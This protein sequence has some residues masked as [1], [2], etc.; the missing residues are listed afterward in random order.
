MS[1]I[2]HLINKFC[3]TDMT[4][5]VY[6]E[7]IQ[8]K[9]NKVFNGLRVYERPDILSVYDNIILGIEHF[10]FYSYNRLNKEGSDS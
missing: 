2:E 1:E 10:E 6:Y 4:I 9:F 5:Q 3:N 8:D 7:L